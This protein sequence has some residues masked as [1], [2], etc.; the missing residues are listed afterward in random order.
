MLTTSVSTVLSEER[1]TNRAVVVAD[2]V[3]AGCESVLCDRVTGG[4]MS[5]K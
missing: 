3:T 2:A 4:G 5:D 1:K